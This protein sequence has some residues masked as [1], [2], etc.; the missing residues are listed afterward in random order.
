M[1]DMELLE[2]ARGHIRVKDGP[3]SVTAYGEA[4]LRGHGS[5]DF[6]LYQ[7]SIEKW[8]PPNQNDG[9]THAEKD[10]VIQFIKD[11]FSRRKISLEIE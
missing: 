6:V 9:L 8:D 10:Q 11:E 4:F 1:S 7:N 5:P 2:I 3:R